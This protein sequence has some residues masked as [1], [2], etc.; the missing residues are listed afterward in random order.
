MLRSTPFLRSLAILA[1]A[2]AIACQPPPPSGSPAARYQMEPISTREG[3]RLLRFDTA[4]GDLWIA[5]LVGGTQWTQVGASLMAIQ[6][7]K[8][9]GRFRFEFVQA[10]S[11]PLLFLRMDTDTGA[12][13]R[14]AYPADPR[15]L[16]YQGS[17]PR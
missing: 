4:T 11:T 15:W 3:V 8:R 17:S 13:W 6:G 10:K 12:A 5:P 14:L 16:A 1:F 2:T 7:D 9:P